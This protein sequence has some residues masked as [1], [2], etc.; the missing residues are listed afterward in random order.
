MKYTCAYC[1]F[2]ILSAPKWDEDGRPYCSML[3]HLRFVEREEK[4]ERA[5]RESRQVKSPE[6]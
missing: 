3:H 5:R 1:G 4:K 6:R 2:L